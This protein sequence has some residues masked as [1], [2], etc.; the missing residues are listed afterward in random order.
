MRTLHSLVLIATAVLAALAI[1]LHGRAASLVPLIAP[2]ALRLDVAATA[3]ALPFLASIVL[4]VPAVAL[5]G[6]RR[7]GAADGTRLAAFVVA[8]I[9][10]F[11]AQSVAAFF[12]AWETM[13]LVSALLIAAHH[14][15]RDVRRALL[16]YLIVSQF[17]AFCILAALAL[18]AAHAGSTRFADIAQA[19][20]SL[21]PA[22]R[23]AAFA[24]AL[25][26]FGSKAGLVPLHFW[27]PRAHPVAPANASALLSGVMLNV[28]VYGLLVF[29]FVLAAP[30]PAAWGFVVLGLGLVSAVT[31][32]LFAAVD[33]DFKRLLAYSS[34]ENV[35]I[36][37]ATLG[38]AVAGAAA[39]L[40]V[41]TDYA[42][43]ALLLHA[44]SHGTFKALLFL[45][46]GTVAETAHTT[47]LEHLGGLRT[48]LPFTTPFVLVGCLAAAAL[49]P[50]GG[51]VA[52]WVVLQSF[53]RAPE[54]TPVELRGAMIVAVAM[55]ALASGLAALAFAKLFGIAFLGAPRTT[56]PV[57]P[58][59]V[60]A[61]LVG[62]AWLVLAVLGI[63]CVPDAVV[64]PLAWIAR[65]LTDG[66]VHVPVVPFPD[67]VAVPNTLWVAAYVALPVLCTA[68]ALVLARARGVRAVPTW[69]CG[70]PVT[71]RSQYTATAFS[72]PL[73]RIFAFAL[74]PDRRRI[75]D[76][77]RSPWFPLRI[78][79]TVTTRDAVDEIARSVAAFGQRFAR[80]AR[81][82]Q[83]GRLRVYI[84]YAVVAVLVL[85]VA[86]R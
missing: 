49:P 46:A 67:N 55:L 17:G 35:G 28:A 9:G 65:G 68:G 72:K 37:V 71:V 74:L 78:R 54:A 79:Y 45:G 18:L 70:S 25:A 26:G 23:S 48:A 64:R 83:A 57:V 1:A 2:G 27:L 43:I 21:S 59:R 15:R 19:A 42:V 75:A 10:V 80:R 82:V 47:N 73:R 13:A 16:S 6:L 36:V 86:A 12:V 81:I 34:I 5:W 14:E 20:P 84:A 51:F 61:S 41:V 32:A 63:G 85:L 24:L 77:G 4:I 8:M 44:V 69:S 76:L 66:V 33:G 56:H 11:V 58:E 30:L 52:E 50:T 7:G 53:I 39:R 40:W 38:L 31:G 3:P 22:L 62:P 60:D 29:A